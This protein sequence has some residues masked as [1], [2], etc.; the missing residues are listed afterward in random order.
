MSITK[1]KKIIIFGGGTS[2][3]LTAAYITKNLKFP[4]EV[5]LIESTDLGPVGVGEGTQPATARFLFDC[6]LDPKSWMKPSQAAFKLGVHF[7]GWTPE[8][9][10][11]DNDFIENTVIAPDLYTTDYFLGRDKKEFFDWLP[12]YQ[13]A[14]AN[15]S[16]K[17]AGM[18]TNYAQTGYRQFGAVHFNAYEIIKAI[19]DLIFDRI[20]YV[21]TKIENIETNDAGIT[22]LIDSNGNKYIADLYL[23]CSGF[24]SVLLEKKLGIPFTSVNDILPC[25]R[26]VVIQ[27]QYTNPEEECVPYT[28]S[29]AMDSGW[30][31]TI[32]KFN[33][34]GNGYVYSSK[35]I[36]DEDAEKEL[37]NKINEF[38]KPA[39]VL[40]M[41]CGIHNQVAYK[42]VLG[43]GLAAGFVEPLEATGVTFTTKAVE[44]LTEGLNRTHGV[45]SQ[46][47]K[48]EINEIY[49]LMFWEI[50]AFVWAHYHFSTK[51]DTPFW[52]NIH[53]QPFNIIPRKVLNYVE[54]FV[55]SPNR[56]FFVHPTSSFHVGHWFSI[57]NAGGVYDGHK[58]KLFG[59]VEKYAEY[60][61]NSQSQRV[62]LVKG[63]FPNHYAFLKEWYSVE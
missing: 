22:A 54:K 2:G 20:N 49:D 32:T 36:S 6:G 47:L 60:F 3:W 39:R 12:A 56:D 13:L 62:A 25:D 10:F 27:T 16:P 7:K 48:N 15:K 38:E 29:T 26:A 61:T 57:L 28:S 42:N 41:K 55:P 21:N 37:R 58:K 19:K 46:P 45:W 51:N 23:D 17:L 31:F 8:N 1:V 30:M 24:A 59:D 63:M 52:D 9:Y 34:Q 40:N 43:I 18:D 11:V 53:K 44:M 50:V 4:C 14:M 33:G 5:M 35:F